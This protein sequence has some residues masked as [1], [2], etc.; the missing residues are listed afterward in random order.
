MRRQAQAALLFL[1]GAALLH[2]GTT[3]L[4]LR[5]VKA[6]LRPLLLLS[7]AV[8]IATALAT[9]WY[10]R[11]PPQAPA[12][13]PAPAQTDDQEPLA[14]EAA[15]QEPLAQEAADQEP[16]AQEAADQ[17]PLAQEADDQ[18]PPAP[19]AHAPAHHHEPRISWLL[20]LPQLAHKQGAP[21]P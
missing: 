14:Q 13:A 8:L 2:A 11:K 5:Y 10:E 1:L 15:D 16:L 6:G 4:Y 20:A 12:Q 9:A 17:Q 3:D 19:S 18:E 21:P 7:A